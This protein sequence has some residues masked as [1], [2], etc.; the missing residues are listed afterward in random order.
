MPM[1]CSRMGRLVTGTVLGM[2]LGW[3]GVVQAALITFNFEGNVNA[4]TG[5]ID[6]DFHVGD[7]FHGSYSFNSFTPDRDPST[8]AGSYRLANASL[9]LGG[10]TYVMGGGLAG[11]IGIVMNDAV[12][13]T[14]SYNVVSLLTGA[15]VN[16]VPPEGFTLTVAGKNLFT[17]DAL[18]LTPPSLSNLSGNVMRF[19]MDGFVVGRDGSVTGELTSLTSGTLAPVPLPGAVLLFGT[20]L[21]SLGAF[22]RFRHTRQV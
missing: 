18:P 6:S 16:G 20:G 21:I 2:L 12:Y 14:Q 15:S 3:G 9:M 13:N 19:V 4:V 8:A 22:A 11:S 17:S 1:G 5:V 10:K 7:T